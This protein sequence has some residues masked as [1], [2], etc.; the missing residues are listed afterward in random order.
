[1]NTGKKKVKLSPYRP[2]RPLGLREVEAPTVSD[3]RLIDGGS[4]L[5]LLKR[6]KTRF[7]FI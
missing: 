6:N 7:S 1:M 5:T 4:K 3:I 2:W